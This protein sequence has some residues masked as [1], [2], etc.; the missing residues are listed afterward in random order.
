MGGAQRKRRV[1]AREKGEFEA[2]T[3]HCLHRSVKKVNP[4]NASDSLGW[5]SLLTP[6]STLKFSGF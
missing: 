2:K 6:P 3:K 1:N 4:L 5:C